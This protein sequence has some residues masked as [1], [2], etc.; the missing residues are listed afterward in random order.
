MALT[1]NFTATQVLGF[2]SQ[3]LFTDTSTGSDAAIAARRIYL[4]DSDGEY[5]V[6]EGT[7]TDYEVWAYAS[8]TKTL[9]LLLQDKAFVIT[10]DWV[11]SAGTVLYTKTT[12]TGFLLYAKTY[13]I[14]LIKSQSSRRKLIDHANFY[15]NEIKL[16]CSIQEAT[17]AIDLAGDIGSAQ[18]AM[19]RAK[20]LI[21]NP[22]YFF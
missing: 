6:V 20:E 18:A 5:N 2:P 12:L 14:N 17:N 22:S 19:I 4:L 7:A 21:D 9:D 13:Y 3:I 8:A 11:N 1:E 15:T 16:L 10:V